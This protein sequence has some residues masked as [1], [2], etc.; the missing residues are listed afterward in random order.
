MKAFGDIEAIKN[1]EESEL[2][3]V[4]GMNARAA[5]AVYEFFHKNTPIWGCFCG[6]V[7]AIS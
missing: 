3:E 2:A 7:S 6:L 4:D 5:Q 1:A